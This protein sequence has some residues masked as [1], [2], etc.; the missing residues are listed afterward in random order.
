MS[1]LLRGIWNSG[2]FD[3]VQ[4]WGH[5][6]I[7]LAF[8]TRT[9]AFIVLILLS[10]V[11][12]NATGPYAKT[13]K[14]VFYSFCFLLGWVWLASLAEMLRYIEGASTAVEYGTS[15]IFIPNM[16]ITVFLFR[17]WLRFRESNG[18]KQHGDHSEG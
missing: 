14:Q 10:R 15:Y 2:F 11:F 9:G 1:D 6:L 16:L 4:F 5:M 8:L 17:L 7:G 13:F 3:P 12:S 18:G